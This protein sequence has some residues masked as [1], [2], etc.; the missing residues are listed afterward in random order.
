MEAELAVK[1]GTL[2]LNSL[3]LQLPEGFVPKTAKVTTGSDAIPA[4]AKTEKGRVVVQFAAEA[5]VTAGNTLKLS[6]V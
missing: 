1:W 4:V 2:Q 3:A 6:L 5:T